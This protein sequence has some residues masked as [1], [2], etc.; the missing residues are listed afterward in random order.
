MQRLHK[1]RNVDIERPC[2]VRLVSQEKKQ[3]IEWQV[4]VIAFAEKPWNS[5]RLVVVVVCLLG[6]Y[7]DGIDKA[8][9][10]QQ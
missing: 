9:K 10:T 5:R 8:E 2:F 7:F 1:D 6:R 3:N 4:S